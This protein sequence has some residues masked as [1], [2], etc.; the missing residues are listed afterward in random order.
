MSLFHPDRYE[1]ERILVSCGK[2][3]LIEGKLQNQDAVVHIR[4]ERVLPLAVTAEKIDS[5]DFY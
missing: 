5:H 3:L 1:R 4:A 2:F